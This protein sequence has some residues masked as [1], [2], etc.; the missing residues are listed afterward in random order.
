M[1]RLSAC[2]GAVWYVVLTCAASTSAVEP[3]PE[4]IAHFTRRVQPLLL[5]ACA[6]GACHGRPDSPAPQF[7]RTTSGTGVNRQI[8]RANLQA[9]LEV[10]GPR[11]D[12]RDL[13]ALLARRHP[14]S[15][16]A[17]SFTARP[18]SSEQR[19]TLETWLAMV[20]SE[21]TRPQPRGA[22]QLASGVEESGQPSRP[23][24]L[25]ALLDAAAQPPT[26]PPPEQPRGLIFGPIAPP[27]DSSEQP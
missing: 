1:L 4:S 25:R 27:E 19:A 16:P 8:T 6:A 20:R 17:G 9:F 12:P 13:V 23:N 11:R 22:V 26:L 15:A 3:S 21:E 10:V 2:H 18:L 7:E 14:A 24:R 5:N